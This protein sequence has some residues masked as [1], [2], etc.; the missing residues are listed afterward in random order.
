[1][2]T[3]IECG[4]GIP[5]DAHHNK[6]VCSPACRAVRQKSHQRKWYGQNVESIKSKNKAYREGNREKVYASQKRSKAKRAEHYAER[7]RLNERRLRALNP[8]KFRRRSRD[9]YSKLSAAL[10]AIKD[11]G[12]N[13]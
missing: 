2:R 4:C 11:L 13:I 8:E 10:A 7:H 5:Q 1:M 3:C 12:V 6:L 9:R